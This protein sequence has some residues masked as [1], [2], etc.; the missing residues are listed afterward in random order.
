VAP[1]LHL[2]Q[3]NYKVES[4]FIK[5]VHAYTGSQN[6]VDGPNRKDPRRGRSASDAGIIPTTTGAHKAVKLAVP[7][8]EDIPVFASALRIPQNKASLAII[9]AS[10]LTAVTEEQIIDL[11]EQASQNSLQGVLGIVGKEQ[12]AVASD[13]T[14]RPIPSILDASQVKVLKG[15]VV[16][17]SLWYDNEAGYVANLLNLVAHISQEL[18][19]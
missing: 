17:L 13:F 12:L 11:F 19:K 4:A 15:K 9:T 1:A 16:E 8:L 14:G 7:G 10:L 5:T 3:Q 18:N 2:L 6:L